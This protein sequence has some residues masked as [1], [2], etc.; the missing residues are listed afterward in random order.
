MT[1]KEAQAFEDKV[2]SLTAKEIILTMVKALR[3]PW[4]KIDMSTF[5]DTLYSNNKVCIGCAATNTICEIAGIK[6]TPSNIGFGENRAKRIKCNDTEF[7]FR[8]ESA[9]DSL[10]DGDIITYNDYAGEIEIATIPELDLHLPRID[11]ND[12]VD[13]KVP[14]EILAQYENYANQL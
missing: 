8:F 7:L 4:V 2:K 6:F 5:G 3:N 1:A 11:N 12:L 10:R 13:G 9:I 14:E